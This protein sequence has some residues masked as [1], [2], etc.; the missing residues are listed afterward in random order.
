[1]EMEE[2][3]EECTRRGRAMERLVSQKDHARNWKMK[4]LVPPL[5]GKVQMPLIKLVLLYLGRSRVV[6]MRWRRGVAREQEE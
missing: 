6:A 1:M 3:E 2:E 4:L 5:K